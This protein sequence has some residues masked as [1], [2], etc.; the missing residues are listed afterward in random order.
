MKMPQSTEELRAKFDAKLKEIVDN[1]HS[2][3][4]HL[5]AD[6]FR[7]I[8]L[9]LEELTTPGIKRTA[10]DYRL[11]KKYDLLQ[12]TIDNVVTKKLREKDSERLY[13]STDKIFDAIHSEHLSAGHGARDITHIKVSKLY[14]NISREVVS[15]YLELCETCLLKKKK[16]EKV[17]LFG[18]LYLTP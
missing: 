15:K 8:T 5:S 16:S 11:C 17:S 12:V 4:R 14:A 3:S 2:C 1:K 6:K 18:L 9:R 7:W 13:V 10:Q